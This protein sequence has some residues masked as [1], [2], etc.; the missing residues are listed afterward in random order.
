M[1]HEG[2]SVVQK[3][4]W[5]IKNETRWYDE[6]SLH[7]EEWGTKEWMGQDRNDKVEKEEK[8]N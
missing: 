1:G 4:R 7:E 8:V 3:G 2:M 5:D 6:V